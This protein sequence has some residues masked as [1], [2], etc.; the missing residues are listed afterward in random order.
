MSA[1]ALEAAEGAVEGFAA[2]QDLADPRLKRLI[3]RLAIP[4]VAGLSI[5]ALHHVANAGFVGLL[6][7]EALAAVSVAIPVFALVAALGHGLGVGT[8][9]TVGRLLGA[10]AAGDA[11]TAATTAL[12]LS[13]LLGIAASV[14]LV[15]WQDE[16]LT[17]FGAT[18]GMMPQARAYIGPLAFSCALLLLQITCDFIAIAEGNSRFSMWTLLGGFSLNIALD[19]LLIFTF[20][21]GIGGAAWATILSQVAAL[22]AYAAYFAFGWGRVRV[23]AGALTGDPAILRPMLAVGVPVT[24]SSALSALAFALVYRAASE[25][26]GDAAV[27]GIGI[28]FRLLTLGLLPV[29]GFCLGAQAVLSFAYGAGDPQRVR[30]ATGF[31]LRAALGFTLVYS[32]AMALFAG[33]VVGVFTQDEAT[34]GIARGALVLFHM[35]FALAG[36][37][38]VLLVLL[39]AMGKARLAAAVG[40]APQGYLL[41]PLLIVLSQSFGLT[42]VVMA[43]AIATGLTALISAALLAREM[44]DLARQGRAA[45]H[46]PSSPPEIA[47]GPA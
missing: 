12:A 36:L 21:L 8:A 16:V 24:L 38:C 2:P 44:A 28:A 23:H 1:G 3:L 4:S 47:R 29:T 18:A 30:A 17:M 22:A 43:P 20:D 33:P 31:M 46:A 19:P 40:L 32:L 34:A 7:P 15:A 9:A 5:T 35:G 10:G 26:G 6:G 45:R 41:I 39:Q 25:Q 13:V 27:A 11:D 37:Q 14:A 42:G